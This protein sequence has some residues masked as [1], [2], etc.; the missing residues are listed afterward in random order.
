MGITL[1]QS[2]KSSV[3]RLEGIIDIAVAAEFK[4]VLLQASETGNAI[5]VSIEGATGLDVTA[6][7]LIWAARRTAE[8][9]DAAFTVSGAASESVSSALGSAGLEQF[10][11]S[12]DAR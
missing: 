12:L 10:L 7:Q 3:I 4:K 1:E 9:A 2:E 11:V 6:V 8:G 5:E